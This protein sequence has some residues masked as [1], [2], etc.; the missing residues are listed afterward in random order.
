MNRED[1][2]YKW[3]EETC[4]VPNVIVDEHN[5]IVTID[6]D[7]SEDGNSP[8]LTETYEF[9]QHVS[10]EDWGRGVGTSFVKKDRT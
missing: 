8:Q 9:G 10:N 4:P 7:V 6:F 5:D 1:E 2:F 3:L